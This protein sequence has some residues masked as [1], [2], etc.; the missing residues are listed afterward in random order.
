MTR[1]DDGGEGVGPEPP[2]SRRLTMHRLSVA[3][4]ETLSSCPTRARWRPPRGLEWYILILRVLVLEITI[5]RAIGRKNPERPLPTNYDAGDGPSASGD[6]E[7]RYRHGGSQRLLQDQRSVLLPECVRL[8]AFTGAPLNSSGSVPNLR[9]GD[10]TLVSN[11]MVVLS[12]QRA[13]GWKAG[14]YFVRGAS[15][16]L[17]GVC[18]LMTVRVSQLSEP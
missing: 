12:A 13:L 14:N 2:G 8:G 17:S 10:Y 6:R 15:W 16:K 18:I 1:S 4:P 5:R 3:S 9:K 7:S 11:E